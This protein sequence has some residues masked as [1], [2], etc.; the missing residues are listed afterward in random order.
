MSIQPHSGQHL[1]CWDCK[2]PTPSPRLQV[3]PIN[4]PHRGSLPRHPE[5]PALLRPKSLGLVTEEQHFRVW[6]QN[7]QDLKFSAEE[8]G[9]MDQ[10]HPSP[11]LLSSP[12]PCRA[13]EGPRVMRPLP[14][15]L[16]HLIL[17]SDTW[18]SYSPACAA[19]GIGGR[20]TRVR[21]GERHPDSEAEVERGKDKNMDSER[22][23]GEAPR[24]QR[25]S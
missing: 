22:L 1:F 20:L 5:A 13:L 24:H 4:Q 9:E 6:S 15:G 25:Q 19:A 16:C 11:S 18:L 3:N 21:Q 7:P 8:L 17:P 10:K 23:T 14:W 12:T 2:F